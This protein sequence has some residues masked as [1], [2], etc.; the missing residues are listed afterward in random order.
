MKVLG[1]RGRIFAFC[2][3]VS[4]VL[5]SVSFLVA[6]AVSSKS[7]ESLYLTEHVGFA[8]YQ[9]LLFVF[10]IFSS[11]G[12]F[13]LARYRTK[14]ID[15]DDRAQYI[16][17]HFKTIKQEGCR[18]SIPRHVIG[19][20]LLTGAVGITYRDWRLTLLTLVVSGG[21]SVLSNTEI[22]N[23]VLIKK[24]RPSVAIGAALGA[25]AFLTATFSFAAHRLPDTLW[26]F[27]TGLC[28]VSAGLAYAATLSTKMRDEIHPYPQN[29]KLL[30][31]LSII[32]RPS[33][34]VGFY[35]TRGAGQFSAAVALIILISDALKFIVHG[36]VVV[37]CSIVLQLGVFASG[38]TNVAGGGFFAFGGML[39]I[40]LYV[41]LGVHDPLLIFNDW[42]Y[43]LVFWIIIPFIN[44]IF[45][46]SRWTI[47]KKTLE[48]S[49][50]EFSRIFI[51]RS[52][53]DGS[54]ARGPDC[55]GNKRHSGFQCSCSVSRTSRANTN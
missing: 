34:F 24:A 32:G 1:A 43:V 11:I 17:K 54:R 44:M 26:F 2:M 9:R 55:T 16:D 19:A 30:A 36:P 47:V 45:D 8:N 38:A 5:T 20:L 49:E 12:L 41:L 39:F 40:T 25:L 46:A 53:Y 29:N 15:D 6:V 7:A 22:P 28:V 10:V 51:G 18:R 27:A 31:F 14:P 4:L 13:T 42:S 21:A 37:A 50:G 35:C 23:R 52:A 48:S 3:A 33:M